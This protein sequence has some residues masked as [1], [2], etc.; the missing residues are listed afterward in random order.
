MQS[1]SSWTGLLILTLSSGL[2]PGLVGCPRRIPDPKIPE[3]RGASADSELQALIATDR[4]LR[5]V[6]AE[7]VWALWVRGE[8]G[9]VAQ[10]YDRYPA[11]A[12]PET[13]H[14]LGELRKALPA[15]QAEIDGL[16]KTVIAA[17]QAR[18]ST[19][20]D[21]RIAHLQATATL[22]LDG[23]TLPWRALGPRLA[24]ESD[25][26][27]RRQLR[28]GALEVEA[29][30]LLLL[31]EREGHLEQ[32][33]GA[34]GLSA[35]Q[36]RDR[37]L[38]ASPKRL[39]EAAL[40]ILAHEEATFL[41]QLKDLAKQRTGKAL[42]Q[43]PAT[44][45]GRLFAAGP[46]EEVGYPKAR[47]LDDLGALLVLALPDGP[48]VGAAASTLATGQNPRQAPLPL[49]LPVAPPADLRLAI[50]PRAGL[51]ARLDALRETVICAGLAGES[52]P[53][54][55]AATARSHRA[56]H[57][58]LQSL[59]DGTLA[60]SSPPL[61]RQQVRTLAARELLRLRAEARREAALLLSVLTPESEPDLQQR[62][63]LLGRA[64]PL[65]PAPEPTARWE[66]AWARA[67]L[68]TLAARVLSVAL[69]H[70]FEP[71]PGAGKFAVR[72]QQP[73]RPHLNARFDRARTLKE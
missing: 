33:A 56:Q 61:P 4:A 2:A 49:C 21:R 66:R 3:G 22:N 69:A 40:Q 6:Q 11:L 48:D 57:L 17:H 59:M 7:Q 44:A 30:L 52:P 72:F 47:L 73:R 35:T 28:E 15:R 65:A 25:A 1:L 23:V 64:L 26:R 18:A 42:D 45:L 20:V 12:S 8:P 63:A 31:K 39:R 62:Q 53:N 27:R 36:I 41:V 24:R 32:A 34:L 38:P 70:G 37:L 13:F 54:L 60:L 29:R 50:A 9:G 14:R 10:S 58:V 5:A 67:H 51:R 68:P 71:P 46:G 43:L 55:K 19:E 16:I